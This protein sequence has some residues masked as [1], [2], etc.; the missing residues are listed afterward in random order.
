MDRARSDES[1]QHARAREATESVWQAIEQEFGMLTDLEASE[2]VTDYAIALVR[3][4][5]PIPDSELAGSRTAK[6]IRYEASGLKAYLT[7]NGVPADFTTNGL[8]YISVLTTPEE[9]A[10]W[11]KEIMV[12][13]MGAPEG[14]FILSGWSQ[15][16]ADSKYDSANNALDCDSVKGFLKR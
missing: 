3:A 15:V 1:P 14:S 11:D 12:G 16:G 13:F 2:M 9:E 8:E 10:A 5:K 7:A 6:Q 4:G